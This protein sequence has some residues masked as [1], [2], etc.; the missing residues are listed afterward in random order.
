MYERGNSMSGPIIRSPGTVERGSTVAP[1]SA[2]APQTDGLV[3][4]VRTNQMKHVVVVGGG[5]SGLTA[6]LRLAERGFLVTL[7]ERESRVGGQAT[8]FTTNGLITEHGTHAWFGP[9]RFYTD[10]TKLCEELGTRQ[11]LDLVKEWTIAHGDGQLAN[12]GHSRW[13]SW[14]PES[15]D[16]AP[17]I[18]RIP[19]LDFTDK[20]RALWATYRLRQMSYADLLRND[21]KTGFEIGREKGYSPPGLDTFNSATH[22]LSNQTVR[23][24][25]APVFAAMHDVLFSRDGL[26][27]LQANRGLHD[28][29]G[30]PLHRKLESLGVQIITN[31]KVTNIEQSS[32]ANG[33]SARVHFET[34]SGRSTLEAP[35][36]IVAAQ[37]WD[38]KKFLPQVTAPWV[39][40]EP[41]KP[42]YT[43]V[44]VL[45][46]PINRITDGRQI[47]FSRLEFPFSVVRVL[48]HS[49]P[50]Y[51]GP[52]FTNKSVV[53]VEIGR[54]Q[55]LPP[56][57][58]DEELVAMVKRGLEIVYPEIRPYR[59]ERFGVHREEKQLYGSWTPGAFS[60]KPRDASERII[61]ASIYCGVDSLN[62]ETIGMN[63]AVH[64]GTR[65]ANW[66]LSRHG[67]PL[68]EFTD[69]PVPGVPHQ[70]V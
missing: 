34:P 25:G 54:T 49:W 2:Q 52:E 23:T 35:Y 42:I 21:T 40:L 26:H 7:L 20:L 9:D 5:L 4:H 31:A 38:A 53:H 37:P 39:S 22:G 16:V 44:M 69:I 36:C 47:G 43:M 33:P 50:E 28:I 51:Q 3:S 56:G 62:V 24:L 63:A 65:S 70:L 30:G 1:F 29:F 45:S 46:G 66:V 12:L 64:A 68:I 32:N 13:L 59:V 58:S 61:S 18:M 57:M 41:V 55:A 14:L 10:V 19:W 67:L 17:S 15:F 27:Y 6:A 11:Y 48:S 60:K 8:H